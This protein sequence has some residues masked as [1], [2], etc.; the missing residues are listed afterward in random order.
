M[1]LQT[2]YDRICSRIGYNELIDC[3][4]RSSYDCL[5]CKVRLILLADIPAILELY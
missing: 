3:K 1:A 5:F 2:V 4:L